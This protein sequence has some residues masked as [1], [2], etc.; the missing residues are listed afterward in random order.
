MEG[1]EDINSNLPIW[2][3]TMFNIL[4]VPFYQL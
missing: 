2:I 4:S 1:Y 3:Q